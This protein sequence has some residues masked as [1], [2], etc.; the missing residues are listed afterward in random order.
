MDLIYQLNK[1]DRKNYI[2]YEQ[3]ETLPA[4]YDR[5][6]FTKFIMILDECGVILDSSL[7]K[8]KSQTDISVRRFLD[9]NRKLNTDVYL[10]LPR[11]ERLLMLWRR[12]AF[13]WLDIK[14]IPLID[15]NMVYAYE[16]DEE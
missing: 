5:K 4:V 2:K 11:M 7:Y 3:T 10:V 9:Q 12:Y 13:F 1:E 16:R 8:D 14:R 15:C 6:K